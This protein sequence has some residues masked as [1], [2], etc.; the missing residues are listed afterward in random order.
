MMVGCGIV[1][2]RLTSTV[3]V[4]CV[5]SV[6]ATVILNWYVPGFKPAGFTDTLKLAGVV[7]LA[8][9]TDNQLLPAAEAVNATA[10]VAD[11]VTA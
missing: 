5:P 8:G 3:A 1:T 6:S 10:E 4:D 7:P 2:V 11:T 9:L